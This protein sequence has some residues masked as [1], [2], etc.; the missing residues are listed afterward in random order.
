[1][2]LWDELE[3]KKRHEQLV[4]EFIGDGSVVDLGC[5]VGRY[6]DIIANPDGYMG[7][8]AS[9]QMVDT[10]KELHPGR[11]EQFACVDVLNFRSDV[12]YDDLICIDMVHH[13]NEPVDAILRLLQVWS[14]S[15]YL[16]TLLVGDVR[17]DLYNSTVVSFTDFLRLF[18]SGY[19]FEPLHIERFDDNKFAWV[20]V[21][22][23]GL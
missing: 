6:L 8:D 16:F 23:W 4:A 5:G 18:E 12:G 20:L 22:A 17:E 21:K 13:L 3:S 15:Q 10:A 9:S 7:Y 2:K 14:A 19:E 1:V 11:E